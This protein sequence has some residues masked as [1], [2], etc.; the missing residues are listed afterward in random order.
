MFELPFYLTFAWTFFGIQL[1]LLGALMASLHLGPHAHVG[2]TAGC[3]VLV[4]Y[5]CCD[6]DAVQVFS[7]AVAFIGLV[8]LVSLCFWKEDA[9]L[10]AGGK[11]LVCSFLLLGLWLGVRI[12]TYGFAFPL[13]TLM[14]LVEI[15]GTLLCS[16]AL[17]ITLQRVM[18]A[19]IF[20]GGALLLVLQ[21]HETAFFLAGLLILAL[22]VILLLLSQLPDEDRTCLA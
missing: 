14:E 17:L 18:G 3:I 20:C 11:I 21:L 5:V 13:P 1:L 22:L 8:A 15:A 10:Y 7:P 16:V 6:C 12:G 9:P 4:A 2:L 19:V